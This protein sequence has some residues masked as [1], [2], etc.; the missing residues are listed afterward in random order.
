M[1]TSDPYGTFRL[2]KDIV[3]FAIED[4]EVWMLLLCI[5]NYRNSL[6][7]VQKQEVKILMK[8]NA[9]VAVI[10]LSLVFVFA[11]MAQASVNTHYSFSFYNTASKPADIG[12]SAVKPYDGDP[13]AYVRATNLSSNI[14]VMDA[15]VNVRVRD[16]NAD[17]A[18]Y[19]DTINQ[20]DYRYELLYMPGKNID[21]NTYLLYGNVES[22][23]GYPVNLAGW[24]CP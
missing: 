24:W 13:Y 8:K 6:K 21:G 4:D 23:S 16:S 3:F 15:E 12:D 2:K 20:Y 11:G 10:I 18:T 1:N 22:T 9:I 5:I 7:H 14:H 19:Y 17:Y